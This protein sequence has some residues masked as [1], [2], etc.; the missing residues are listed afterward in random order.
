MTSRVVPLSCATIAAS[1][2]ARRFRRLDT[3]CLASR[4]GLVMT[5]DVHYD[6]VAWTEAEDRREPER[7]MVVIAEDWAFHPAD[8]N[9][10]GVVDC[11]DLAWFSA[12]PYDWNLNGEPGDDLNG[13]A[14]VLSA[15]LADLNGDGMVTATDLVGLLV[16]WGPC[17]FAGPCP[18]DLDCDGV[19]GIEDLLLLLTLVGS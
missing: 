1:R 4:I 10:D 9:M 3:G 6:L 17:P 2:R 5:S 16:N 18:G 14:A 12:S 8:V 11:T 13:L 7:E 19:V 15:A